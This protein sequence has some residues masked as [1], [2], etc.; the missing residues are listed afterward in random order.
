MQILRF[1]TGGIPLSTRERSTYAGVERIRELGLDCMEL[2]F[3][4]GVRLKEDEARRIGE[5]A[6]ELDVRLSAHGPYYINL[7]SLEAPKIGASRGMLVQTA[8]A[9]SWLGADRFTFHA[10]FYQERDKSRIYEMVR[11]QIQK[12]RDTLVEEGIENV[13]IDPE[14][15]GKA[16]QFGDL[17]ELIALAKEI[18]GVQ[19]CVDFAH[20]QARSGGEVNGYD[21][22]AAMLQQIKDG[23][24]QDALNDMHIHMSGINFT[25]KGERN[26]LVLENAD[27][28]WQGLLRALKDF[29]VGGLVICESPN[30]EEDAMKMQKC[31][32]S[33]MA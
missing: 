15:T 13:R 27:I 24:G 25:A 30:L 18:K 20:A 16:T 29:D 3:V 10:A 26:H 14:L 7:A 28:D 11:E 8:Q 19:F 17:T 5:R 6:K 1:G 12:I 21:D 4:H 9:C 33:M 32:N 31:Y 22:F 23:L 2:E